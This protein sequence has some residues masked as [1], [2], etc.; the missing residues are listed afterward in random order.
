MP[1][2]LAINVGGDADDRRDGQH[3]EDV[4]LL[5]A[6]ESKDGVEQKLSL[7][8]QVRLKVHQ[9]CQILAGRLQM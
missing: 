3:L 7:A 5:R 8:R 1:Y 9:R 6:D 4:V 2:M